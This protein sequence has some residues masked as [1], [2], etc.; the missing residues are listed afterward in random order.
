M[1]FYEEW[2]GDTLFRVYPCKKNNTDNK[3][4]VKTMWTRTKHLM[5]L[6]AVTW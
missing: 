6:K 1:E 2:R 3:T 5:K 4:E